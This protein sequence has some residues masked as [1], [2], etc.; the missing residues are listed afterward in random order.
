MPGRD[1]F[2]APTKRTIAERAGYVCSFPRCARLTIGPSDDRAS[3]ITMTGTA[4][5]IVAAASGGQRS[6]AALTSAQRSSANNGIWMCAIHGKWIDDN[7]S[8]ATVP[9]LLSW[10]ADHEAEISAW[11]AHGHPGIFKSWDRLAALTRDQ[12]ETIE[13]SLP[14]GHEVERDAGNLLEALRARG[15]FL[16]TGDSGV[17]KSALVKITLDTH[18]PEV[19][20]VWLGPEALRAALSEAER[21]AI[22]LTAPLVDLL[23]T[24]SAPSN[25]LVVD[26]VERAGAMTMV[27]LG[28]LIQRLS[29]VAADGATRWQL[30]VVAQLAG[31]EAHLD[32]VIT[33]VTESVV[34]DPFSTVQVRQALASVPA[35][36]QH[37]YD[38]AFVALVDNPRM[39]AWIITAGPSFTGGQAGHMATRPQI[40]DR[41]WSYWTGGDSD[42][43]S[44]MI[45]LARRDADYERSFAISALSA[46]DRTAWKSG[47][48]RL[49]LVAD[50]RHR[51]S[52]QHDL[53]TDWAR[54]QSLK[55]IAGDV[56]RWSGL[57]SQPLWVAA[58]RLFGQ[59]LLREPDQSTQGWDWAFAAARAID[60]ADAID[61]LLDALCTDPAAD[62][63]LAARTEI[64]FANDGQLLDRLLTRFMHVATVPERSEI[65]ALGD[66]GMTLY[67]EAEVRSPIWSAWPPLIR[68]LVKYR[69][70]IAPFGSYTVAKI[71]K[72]WLTKTPLLVEGRAVLGRVGI[73]ELALDTA[74]V[75]QVRSLAHSY[76]GS[77][78]DAAS[79]IFEAALAGAEDNLEA[80]SSFALE[81]AR[82]R[83]LAP[84]VQAEVDR[85]R[86][87]ERKMREESARR[88]PRRRREAPMSMSM[89]GNHPL[90]PWPLGASGRLN[91]AFR[92]AVV[93]N[94]GLVFLMKAAPAIAAEVLLACMIDD[95]PHAEHRSMTFDDRLGLQWA[96]EDR[97]TL[98]WTSPFFRF[99][100]QSEETALQ[101]IMDLVEFCTERWSA[102]REQSDGEQIELTLSEGDRRVF[103]GDWQVFDWSHTRRTHNSQL[104][105]AL[106]AL[107]R[108]LFMKV[109]AGTDIAPLCKTLL[110]QTRSAATLGVLTDCA[111]LDPSLLEGALAPLLS[112]PLLIFWDEYRLGYRFGNDVFTWHRAG[113]AARRFGVAWEQETHR[114]AALKHVV[115]DHRRT[116]V[117][118]NAQ[119]TA[120][121]AAWPKA[122]GNRDLR[123]RALIA[124][125]DPTNYQESAGE[126]GKTV[127]SF[128]YPPEIAA[129]IAAL[130]TIETNRP[131]VVDVL[132][133]LQQLL[134]EDLSAEDAAE[135][136]SAF[137]E[138]EDIQRFSD[139]EKH[140]IRVAVAAVLVVRAGAWVDSDP[141][142]FDNLTATLAAAVPDSFEFHG[143]LDGQVHVDPALAWAM[144][145]AIYAKSRSTDDSARWDRMLSFGLATGD[146]ATV[147]TIIGA[148]RLL[149]AELG[150]SYYAIIE[151]SVF[152]AVLNGLVPRMEG[153]P[154]SAVAM[155]RWRGRLA[156]RPLAA[157]RHPVTFDLVDLS[158]RIERI[159]R[160]RFERQSGKDIG[161]VGRCNLHRRYSFGP[162]I[163]LLAATFDWA[164]VEAGWTENEPPPPAAAELAEHRAILRMLWDLTDWR[165][166]G[167]P[168]EEA[169][170]E[171]DG[172]GM[173]DD[174]GLQ[175]QRTI[176][177]RV[178]LGSAAESRMLWEPILALG[179]R[180]EYTLEHLINGF[181]L[182]LYKDI[183]ADNFITNWT[184]MVVFIFAP[185]WSSG[186][187]YWRGREIMRRILGFNAASQIANNPRALAHVVELSPYYETFAR[188]HIPHD[189]SAL[190]AFA[191]FA[192]A[193]T[194]AAIRLAAIDWIEQ[195]IVDDQRRLKGNAAAAL[196]E[197]AQVLLAHHGQELIADARARQALNSV[198]GRMVRD[199][200]PYALTLQDRARGLH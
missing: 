154:G 171:H 92:T 1:N 59:F 103:H 91:D 38:D 144:V 104:Y 27:R 58:L 124:E 166:R 138:H 68:F 96:H 109:K 35:L 26:A 2:S 70:S 12:R 30:V 65:A 36:S 21:N 187:K 108:W 200:A 94:D 42:L 119:L 180:G 28:Q 123:Q 148:A 174:F 125:V 80:V 159:W 29:N 60:S 188:D 128:Q 87:E 46:A 7:P 84:P 146:S 24:S 177:A 182:R 47:R 137:E 67:A 151:T 19:R 162:G 17:G 113:E 189:D 99:L 95:K 118:F 53:A 5:H 44:F 52:F 173:L 69:A 147:R 82:R 198:I 175:I 75:E 34:V 61:I 157:S 3:G 141:A 163:H 4:A 158:Q 90:P 120:S 93:R 142:V 129:E 57:A 40:A 184:A 16:V 140:V 133:Y 64:L 62:N 11:V 37:I 81:M 130:R 143:T 102:D 74:Q 156:R 106:D 115:R 39:L 190:A 116:N 22:G 165:L 168:Y 14:N 56:A 167:D 86:A 85:L 10:K 54:Y 197:L 105:T 31:F 111:K 150:A 145:G 199:Q 33:A 8:I 117:D 195:A 20:Q 181:F 9:T 89:F 193:D 183:D 135:L 186:G 131:T 112:S 136:Y 134:R 169:L 77:R 153:E 194:G 155:A 178:P 122:E 196:A 63:F 164:L 179:P 114:T 6:D 97:P 152:S 76:Y 110:E 160:S 98:F 43:H 50:P 191:S 121:L 48:G 139:H 45:A 83:P 41:L 66:L 15:A 71:C 126:D 161:P 72:Y 73:A 170:E 132:N 13:T 25:I 78:S 32:P 185:G 100:A 55:E 23:Q 127:V 149:K 192:A 101:A 51:L 79:D 107:E 49:P 88:S 18:F 176:A 172:Y